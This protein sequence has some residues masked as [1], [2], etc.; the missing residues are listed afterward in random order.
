MTLQR[1]WVD[2]MLYLVQLHYTLPVLKYFGGVGRELDDSLIVHFVKKVIPKK[3]NRD[4]EL[5]LKNNNILL[6][7]KY[8]NCSLHRN[9]CRAY[10]SYC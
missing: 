5:K 10:G 4:C 8:G 2:R 1:T 6:G 7:I 3:K 9:I